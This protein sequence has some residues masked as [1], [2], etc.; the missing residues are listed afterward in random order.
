VRRYL[1]AAVLFALSPIIAELLF[2]ATPISNL[3]A[4]AAVAPLYGGGAVFIRELARRR[5]SG[6]GRIV[7]LGAAYGIIEEGLAIQSIFNPNLFNAGLVGGRAFGVNWIWS[8]WTVGYHVVWSV[9]IPI[10]LAEVF[11]PAR[12]ALPWLGTGGL[13]IAGILF[14]VGTLALAAVFRTFVTPHFRTP[15]PLVAGAALVVLGLLAL[16][17]CWPAGFSAFRP[18]GLPGRAPSPWFVGLVAFAAAFAWFNL[19]FLPH[20]LRTGALALVPLLLGLLL[21]ASVITLICRWSSAGRGWT[22]L[23]ELALILGAMPPSMLFGFFFVT[24]GN[25][26]DQIGQGVASALALLLLGFYARHLRKRIGANDS[27]AP[28]LA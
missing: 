19:L 11:F 27:N 7:L 21:S 12:R 18:A 28:N 20:S 2:G 10:L 22:E 26:V 6:W 23:H 24:I 25:R 14:T 15:P 1:P 16:S 17:L 4:L 8:E 9:S 3:G 5:G 13:A